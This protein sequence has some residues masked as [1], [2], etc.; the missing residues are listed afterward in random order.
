MKEKKNNKNSKNK[1]VTKKKKKKILRTKWTNE[2]I[3]GPF[4]SVH[5]IEIC[6]IAKSCSADKS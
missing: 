5:V 2:G 4:F 6:F 3:V 1:E